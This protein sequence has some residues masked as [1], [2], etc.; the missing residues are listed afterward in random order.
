MTLAS[1]V[2]DSSMY[3]NGMPIS[4]RLTCGAVGVKWKIRIFYAW[5]SEARV[6]RLA[7]QGED[8]EDALV[9]AAQRLAADEALQAFDAERELPQR[10]RALHAEAARA[11][12]VEVRQHRV[13][14]AVDDPQVLRPPA[15]HGRLHQPVRAAP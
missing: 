14:R 10:Q 12:P 1:G 3:K 8:A 6:H 13:L 11:Q 5:P 2:H 4:T 7:F 15:L 9:D